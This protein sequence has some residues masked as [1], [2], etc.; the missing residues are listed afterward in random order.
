MENTIKTYRSDYKPKTIIDQITTQFFPFMGKVNL[1]AEKAPLPRHAEGRFAIPRWELVD[2]TYHKAVGK[3]LQLIKKQRNGNFESLREG[4]FGERYLRQGEEKVKRMG[5]LKKKY[6]GYDILPVAAQF[7]SE[8]EGLSVN[9]ARSLFLPGEFGL[10]LFEAGCMFLAH[11]D[12]LQSYN[13]LWIIC[14]G[15][16]YSPDGDGVFSWVPFF[17]FH[18]GMVKLAVCQLDNKNETHSVVSAIMA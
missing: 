15:D 8:Y 18:K 5:I 2:N 13:G 1:N 12:R 6:E 10:G 9:E 11:P 7:G 17:F 14:S 4:R 3:I 16:E